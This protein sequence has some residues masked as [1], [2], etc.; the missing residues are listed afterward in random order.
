MLRQRYHRPSAAVMLVGF[1]VASCTDLPVANDPAGGP[2]ELESRRGAATAPAMAVSPRFVCRV[3][4]LTPEGPDRYRYSRRALRFSESAV[5]PGGA[6]QV[7]RYRWETP[8]GEVLAAANCRIPATAYARQMVDRRYRIEHRRRRPEDVSSD[9][10]EAGVLVV[11]IG[12]YDLEPDPEPTCDLSYCESSMGRETG[13]GGD[14]DPGTEPHVDPGEDSMD[15]MPPPDC[16]NPYN[17]TDHGMAWCN[18]YAPADEL[19]A[20]IRSSAQRFRD[21]GGVCAELAARLD[22]LL[23]AGNLRITDTPHA[24]WAAAASRGGDW[25][26]FVRKWI[27]VPNEHET[28]YIFAHEMDHIA[29]HT[30]PG[31]VT[32]RAG[33]LLRDDGTVDRYHTPNSRECGGRAY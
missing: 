14:S 24:G 7:V 20:R 13:G 27:D 26:I 19:L 11:V 10:G 8:Q 18:G 4:R 6:T 5:D 23:A 32:D 17:L 29:D 9:D 31:T 15:Y 30:Y 28:D 21:R 3:S 25:A 33:H 2:P 12:E 16:S 22:A 1:A